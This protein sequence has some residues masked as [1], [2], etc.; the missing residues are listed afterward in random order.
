MSKNR[1]AIY[2]AIF[3]VAL[4]GVVLAEDGQT[5]KPCTHPEARQF[6]FW[7][8]EWDLVWGEG[9]N[10]GTGTNIVT[11]EMDGCV[12]EENFTSDGEDPFIGNSLSVYDTESKLWKQTW[13]DNQGNYLDFAGKFENGRMILQREK[14][15][16]GKKIL[17][18]MIWYNIAE[19]SLDWNWEKSEDDGEKW[20]LL[21]HI[22][23][24]RKSE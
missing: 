7:I 23:Y 10:T 18:R 4:F 3:T 16:G 21:W 9:D 17:Q 1:N 6:D 22:H 8:G 19:N 20:I 24:E 14:F 13:V 2:L 11:S 15:E 5:A 12:I